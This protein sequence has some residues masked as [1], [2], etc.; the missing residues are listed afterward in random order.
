[1][2]EWTSTAD[3]DGRWHLSEKIV[4]GWTILDEA[5]RLVETVYDFAVGERIV[6]DHNEW[7]EWKIAA[8]KLRR[9]P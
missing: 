8:P 5:G 9:K 6:N 2:P 3:L 1:M 7:R 4:D